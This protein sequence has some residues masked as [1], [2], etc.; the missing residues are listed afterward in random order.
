MW[1][2][3]WDS[4]A[5]EWSQWSRFRALYGFDTTDLSVFD[6]VIETSHY[7]PE[8]IVEIILAAARPVLDRILG[9]GVV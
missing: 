7:T 3:L 5:R 9:R 1:E 4:L 2:A 8:E 6:L